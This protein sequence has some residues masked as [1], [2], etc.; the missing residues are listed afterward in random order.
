M[1]LS[2]PKIAFDNRLLTVEEQFKQRKHTLAL[3]ELSGL[4]ESDFE[5][6]AYDTGLYLSLSADASFHEGNY[7]N[8]IEFGLRGARVLA[9]FTSNRRYGR[10]QLI[11]AK[12]YL[13]VGDIKNAD[14]RARDAL[15][16]FR[17]ASD[18][19][20]QVDAYNQL[21][22]VGY[23]RCDYHAAIKFL[24]DAVGM[25]GDNPRK[26]AQL[27]GNM[28]TLR[29]HVG[30][31]SQAEE[32][33][34][35]AL[36]ANEE[37]GFETA[38]AVNLLSLGFLAL[39]RRKFV[40]SRRYFDAA[41]DF[42]ERHDRKR[43]KVI[44]LK[45]SAELALEKG[46]IFQAKALAGNAY[47]SGMLLA[48]DSALVSQA[49]RRLADVELALDNLDDAMKYGQKALDLATSL[50][51]TV[52]VGLAR[53]VIAR[54]YAARSDYSE[55][56][57]NI[58]GAIEDIRNV[59]DPFELARTL[60]RSALIMIEADSDDERRIRSAFD[61]AHK[62]FRK[63]G[64]DYWVAETN[65]R[66]G[67]FACQRGDLSTGFKKLSRAEKRF[68]A[69]GEKARVRAVNQF[70][71]SLAE[72]AVALSVSQENEYKVFGNLI[73]PEELSDLK[74]GQLDEILSVL[75]RK[76][77][78][79]R[80]VIYT[81]DYESDPVIASLPLSKFQ[82]KKFCEN[83]ESLLGEEIDRT[84]PTLNLDCRRDPFINE[85]LADIPDVVASIIVV[86]FTMTDGTVSYLYLDRLT[87]DGTLRPFDQKVLNFA[88][89]FSDLVAFKWAEIL[90]NKLLE[91]NRRLKDQLR[92]QAAFPNIITGNDQMLEMLSQVRQ[93]LDSNI[94]ISIEGETG[95]GKDLLARAI[96]YNSMRRES[97]FI[98]VNCAALPETLLESEL[99]GFRR[100]AFTGA[101]RDK[102]G[103]FEEADGGTFFLDEIADMP[104]S[105]QAKILRVLET[106]E[107][108]RLGETVPRLV[109]VRIVSATNKDL[110]TQMDAGLF[111]QDL[112]YRLSALSFRL[113]PLRERKGDI[114]ILVTHFLEGSSKQ[115]D[116]SVMKHLVAYDW[117]GNV[118]ELDNEIKK[119]I[120]MAGDSGV[121]TRSILSPQLRANMGSSGADAGATETPLGE[122]EFS[123]SYS[124]Y[125][126]LSEY[127]RR[128]IV[129]ALREKQGVKK[130]AA[131]MLNIPESTLRLKIKQYGI[132]PKHLDRLH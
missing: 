95:T 25:L 71:Q 101:D 113:S 94:S 5:S 109:D 116:P 125:D 131:A 85:L 91:D 100:G 24:E 68:V 28:G 105:I 126:Y 130:H 26:L 86:P 23:I 40:D 59:D 92:E 80:A 73:G 36:K 104:L 30:Q 18:V 62:L 64:C 12:S 108:V 45:Y 14:M 54:V 70:L 67:I 58:N 2:S 33:L 123:S 41:Q 57:E 9:D 34:K 56:L 97:R 128:F 15:S 61:E 13:A 82:V 44:A 17:R 90:K 119:L 16:A 10:V 114:P 74:T 47:H 21:A 48:P 63:L 3:R 4:S 121:I 7:K 72:Q 22:Y 110:K 115:I 103:L 65:Y 106:K 83:F 35:A 107:I 49:A 6:K 129:R 29:V 11:L 55:A 32:E 112:Y 99:F 76:T 98:T 31:W 60:L 42:I 43:E 117:P 46:D 38:Q 75:I 53:R 96:H 88:V 124:L 50:G 89:G 102:T 20:G 66:A 127:E 1:E 81:P 118:R 69:L 52:E 78:A 87:D 77:A 19:V 27:T 39:K 120:L 79:D 51:E 122:V 8:S 37:L 132:D 84:K 111:R 93:V